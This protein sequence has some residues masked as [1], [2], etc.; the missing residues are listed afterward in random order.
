[1]FLITIE[2]MENTKKSMCSIRSI[3]LVL[4]G[5]ASS[6]FHSYRTE[7][8]FH[9]RQYY[10]VLGYYILLFCRPLRFFS[11]F[12]FYCDTFNSIFFTFSCD[13]FFFYC[14]TFATSLPNSLRVTRY[15]PKGQSIKW[16]IT[17]TTT[18]DSD[19]DK[20]HLV[21]FALK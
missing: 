20:E 14:V 19:N 7:L 8:F 6:C 9:R 13:F 10:L 2:H 3:H 12:I 17:T 16:G 11:I 15:Y 21:S 1:M 5:F 18:T 4:L